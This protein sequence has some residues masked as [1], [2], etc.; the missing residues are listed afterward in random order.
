YLGCS[1]SAAWQLARALGISERCGWARFDC[2]QPRYNLVD[3]V[4]EREHFPLC[5]D[6]GVGVINYSPLAG[7]ILTGKYA[8]GEA[9]PAGTRGADNPRFMENRGKL[10]NLQRAEA[11]VKVLRE[12]GR[13]VVQAAVKW[14]LAHPAITSPIIGARSMEQLNGF[15]DG[16]DDWNLTPE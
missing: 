6:Q 9:P 10:H 3:R 12:L 16:W 2:L 11:V 15:L 4:V 13:P 7:G 14:T 8:P 5:L 1:N